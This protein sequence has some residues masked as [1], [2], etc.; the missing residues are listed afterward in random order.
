VSK[1][2]AKANRRR[3][4]KSFLQLP[5]ST[6]LSPD[7]DGDDR[8]AST[9]STRGRYVPVDIILTIA[10][11]LAPI[12][13]LSFSLSSSTMRALLMSTL[14]HTMILKSS[15]KCHH[16][17][18]ML[19]NRPDICAHVRKLA[20]RPNYYL[21]WPKRDRYLDEDW[22][23]DTIAKIAPSLTSIHTFDW[24]GLEIPSDHLWDTLRQSCP[25]L[26]NISTNIGTRLVSP[27]SK[28]FQFSDLTTFSLIVRHNV[29]G[30]ELFQPLQDLPDAFWDMILNRCPHL[31]E[32]T[33]CSFSPSS[34]T[35]NISPLLTPPSTSTPRFPQL[36]SLTLGSFGY[37]TD[38]S[39]GPPYDSSFGT[40]LSSH[41]S[42]NYLRLL[43]NFKRWVSPDSV[44]MSLAPHA[45]PQLET[46]VGIYQ[47]LAE[48]P[49][50]HR[51][52][53]ETVDLTCEPVYETRVGKVCEVLQTME[54]LKC[55]DIWVHVVER[56]DLNTRG[57]H[58]AFFGKLVG[59][60]RGLE[61]L[62]FM[63]TTPFPKASASSGSNLRPLIKPLD[64]LLSHLSRLPALRRF[65]LTKGHR[66]R[67]DESMLETA[68]RVVKVCEVLKQV[69]V[70][71]AREKCANHLKQEGVF[72]VER[73]SE[74]GGGEEIALLVHERGIPIFGRP[75]ERRYRH[76]IKIA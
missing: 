54:G 15:Q 55:L 32:L 8:L 18:L 72:D 52:R 39:L 13:V 38:F 31:T 34:W 61:E 21:S 46:F 42:I 69:S 16:T 7:S 71:W 25:E 23:A 43:W 4:L 47:Q 66:Y 48:I 60:C 29:D 59:S 24:D 6:R 5:L 76:L 35:F 49:T 45:L 10:D 28:L 73:R 74:V 57:G 20:V 30:S 44:P 41:P 62:H 26:R 9:P 67:G 53:I 36:S 17:L 63:C 56:R 2:R 70:R 14:Y 40:F 75:F 1:T 64:Q 27:W 19:S 51:R 12:D 33:I 22:V 58:G 37:Q 3:S 50:E 65:A 68:V 11:L